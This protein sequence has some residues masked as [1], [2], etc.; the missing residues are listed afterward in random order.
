MFQRKLKASA[1]I[2][3]VATLTACGQPIQPSPAGPTP[4]PT[5]TV[6]VF[7]NQGNICFSDYDPAARVVKGRGFAPKC[8][9]TSCTQIYD[10]RVSVVL[11]GNAMRFTN[12]FELRDLTR[13]GRDAPVCTADCGV[14]GVPFSVAGILPDARYDVYLGDRKLM[15]YSAVNQPANGWV[16]AFPQ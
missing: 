16:C 2:L 4:A 9:S 5:A 7:D 14:E 10:R 13:S 1:L 15:E 6:T 11:D 12:H 8:W 3:F